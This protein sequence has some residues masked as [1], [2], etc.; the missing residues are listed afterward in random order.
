MTKIGPDMKLAYRLG[1]STLALSLNFITAGAVVPAHAQNFVLEEATIASAQAAMRQGTLTCRDLTQSYLDRIAAYDDK[2]P[3]LNAI[4]TLA[5]DAIKQADAM[6]ARLRS[7]PSDVGSLHCVPVILK[8]N[9]N[10]AD[11]P[12]TGSSEALQ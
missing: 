7:N 5:P 8:D 11:M 4:L 9:Y 3:A 1:C 2:G 12:T 6:D 10:T